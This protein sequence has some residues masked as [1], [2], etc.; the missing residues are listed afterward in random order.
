[1]SY[2]R[3]IDEADATGRLAQLYQRGGNPDGTVDNV[4]K[5]HSLNPDSLH[6]HLE[7]YIS[8]VH[9][10][11]PLSRAEREMIAVTVSR[12]NGCEYCKRHHGEGLRRLLPEDRKHA[13]GELMGGDESSLIPREKA[14]TRYAEML[15]LHPDSVVQAEIDALRT[16]ELDDRAIVDLACVV[17]YFAYANRVVLGLGAGLESA[18][19]IGNIPP[20]S[21]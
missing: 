6:A 12:L 9:R 4:L 18:D 5:V 13:A 20:E 7:L 16:H 19:R 10:P 1:M 11:S 14:L 17:A 21:R 2:V 8:A 15:T 3:T